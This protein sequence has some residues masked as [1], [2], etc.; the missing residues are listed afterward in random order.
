M[1]IRRRADHL[2]RHSGPGYDHPGVALSRPAGPGGDQLDQVSGVPL[3]QVITLRYLLLGQF[4]NYVDIIW[5][6]TDGGVD[7]N[8]LATA[9]SCLYYDA[10]FLLQL[11]EVLRLMAERVGGD[12][13]S[14]ADQ[15]L[16]EV[17][18]GEPSDDLLELHAGP[19]GH[20][21]DEIS[22]VLPVP[23]KEHDNH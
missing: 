12:T 18:T 7:G 20:V 8:V 9:I 15:T 10:V 21:D 3:T 19:A 22:E 17:V 13:V 14:E 16:G 1:A 2:T 11:L 23:D 6:E 4:S 5:L